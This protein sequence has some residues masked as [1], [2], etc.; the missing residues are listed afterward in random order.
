MGLP[1]RIDTPQHIVPPGYARW[2]H[3]KGIR[4]GAIGLPSGSERSACTSNTLLRR[5]GARGGQRIQCRGG[6]GPA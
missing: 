5:G 2:M 1:Y 4:S 3:E 6:G